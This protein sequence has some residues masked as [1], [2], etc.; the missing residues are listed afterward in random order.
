MI[1][2]Y[3]YEVKAGSFKIHY[4]KMLKSQMIELRN[5]V[6]WLSEEDYK[7][8]EIS[9]KDKKLDLWKSMLLDSKD[10]LLRRNYRESIYAINGALENFLNQKSRER[11]KL[12]LNDDEID[13]F[14]EGKIEYDDF[15]LKEFIDK[16]SFEEALASNIIG[17]YP[18]VY[19]IVG[20]CHKLVP[21]SISKKKINSIVSKIKKRRNDIIHGNEIDERS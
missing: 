18:S 21:F 12:V 6:P 11:L 1:Q 8:L 7:N 14:F 13:E 3:D 4:G 5:D 15:K 20:K 16:D 2:G 10:Y 9:L 17:D 19:Q